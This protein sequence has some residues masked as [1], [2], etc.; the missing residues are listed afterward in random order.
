MAKAKHP[1]EMTN[2]EALKHLFHPEVV[3]HVKAVVKNSDAAKIK[4]KKATK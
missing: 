1:R 2:E 3:K 4:K